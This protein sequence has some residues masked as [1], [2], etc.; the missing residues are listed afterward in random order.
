MFDPTEA[1]RVFLPCRLAWIFPRALIDGLASRLAGH[2]PETMARVHLVV[3][4]RRMARRIRDLFDQG[5]P[6][7]L[8]RLSLVAD[9]FDPRDAAAMPPAIP[10]LRRRLELAQLV[11]DLLDRQPDLAARE[12]VFA[13][14]DSLAALIDEMHGE[15]VAPKAIRDLDVSDL[16]GHWARAQA[17]I[18][19]AEAFAGAADDGLDPQ[20]RLRRMVERMVARWETDP[21]DHPVIV[22]GSTG[23]RGT[24]LMLMQAVARLPQGA[25]ILPGFDF[26]MPAPVWDGLDDALTAEDHPQYRFRKLMDGLGIGP[27]DV[28]RWTDTAPRVAR[29]QPAGVAGAAACAR[30]GCLDARGATAGRD[31]PRHAKCNPDRGPDPRA[32]RRWP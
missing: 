19:I 17:F 32:K 27:G 10:P 18:G 22:A 3:N 2:P 1:P 26:D 29:T 6:R 30:D 9:P 23:S 21:P 12:S 28:R 8:P 4:T 13:L 31:R 20:G 11:A 15:G 7:L 14:A 24:T 16:S 25:V 5:P